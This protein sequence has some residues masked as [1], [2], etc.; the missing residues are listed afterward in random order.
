MK[1]KIR[2]CSYPL[3]NSILIFELHLCIAFPVGSAAR[4]S[5]QEG[6]SGLPG[7]FGGLEQALTRREHSAW[8]MERRD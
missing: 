4:R 2:K 5:L 7:A 6:G 8:L 1:K 3:F